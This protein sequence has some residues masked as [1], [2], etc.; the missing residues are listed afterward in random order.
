MAFRARLGGER[1]YMYFADVHCHILYGVDDGAKS[2]EQMFR[3]ADMAY[4]AGT[5]FLCATP[6]FNPEIF[7]H[8]P[9]RE[10]RVFGELK[11]YCEERYPDLRL[12][13]GSEIMVYGDIREAL[14]KGELRCLG[15]SNNVLVEFLPREE[16]SIIRLAL[17]RI[18]NSGLKPVLAHVERYAALRSPVIIEELKDAGIT[19][20]ANASSVEG[21]NGWGAKRFVYQLLRHGLVDIIASDGHNDK[22]HPPRLDCCADVISKR[23]Y[24]EYAEQLTY[25]NA[26]SLFDIQTESGDE[27]GN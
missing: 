13:L 10:E 11:A 5:R 19:I 15:S 2:R 20:T 23:F 4:G 8:H 24:G 12:I 26:L 25:L 18:R 16:L 3:M 1:A 17:M 21:K 9:H 14:L 22:N 7:R 27:S 6:H